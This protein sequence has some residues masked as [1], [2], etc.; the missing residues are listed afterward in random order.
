MTNETATRLPPKR[1]PHEP[2]VPEGDADDR[3][4]VLR[5][6]EA[7]LLCRKRRSHLDAVSWHSDSTTT[8]P[9]SGRSSFS[10]IDRLSQ[11]FLGLEDEA[12][13]SGEQE[14]G[15]NVREEEQQQ[16][17]Q[18]QQ[19]QELTHHGSICTSKASVA[20]GENAGSPPK[21]RWVALRFS[22]SPHL[23][24]YEYH[25][26]ISPRTLQPCT[27]SS[28]TLACYGSERRCSSTGYLSSGHN[29]AC[30]RGSAGSCVADGCA[31][32]PLAWSNGRLSQTGCFR[33]VAPGAA[34]AQFQWAPTH[35]LLSTSSVLTRYFYRDW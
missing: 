22:R 27:S 26:T 13:D 29:S 24:T 34:Y 14:E 33:R 32:S 28:S 3:K 4:D 20:A 2:D 31:S 12:E 9:T 10:S 17:Q 23:I 25:R 21:G 19:Q 1:A 7:A 16:R 30:R 5:P 18:L 8:A 15:E 6:C 11:L 35:E